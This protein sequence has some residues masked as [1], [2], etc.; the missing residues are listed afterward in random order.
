[1]KFG[2][3]FSAFE[4]S[5]QVLANIQL[6]R[7]LLLGAQDSFLQMQVGMIHQAS[8]GAMYQHVAGSTLVSY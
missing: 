6:Q 8:H 5:L 3:S 4:S 7:S 2:H 1:L